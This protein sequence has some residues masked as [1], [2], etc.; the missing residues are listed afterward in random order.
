MPLP[1]YYRTA[2]STIL[3]AARENQIGPSVGRQKSYNR[4]RIVEK[5]AAHHTVEWTIHILLHRGEIT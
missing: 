3:K 5:L 2:S 1:A 4:H